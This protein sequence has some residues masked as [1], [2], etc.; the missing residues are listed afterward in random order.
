M[1]PADLRATMPVTSEVAYLN[2]GAS[3]P[4]PR[5]VVEAM[6]DW[7][8][9]HNFEAPA[10]AGIY[11]HA[12]DT[13]EAVRETIAGFLGTTPESIGLTGSTAEGISVIASSIDF[14]PGDVLVRTDLEHPAGILPFDRMADLHGLEV[15][16]LET[17]NGRLDLDDL[18]D[19]VADA[20]LLAMSSV[21]WSHG[22]RLPVEEVV[23][24]AHEAG[25]QVLIDAVQSPGQRPVDL[26]SW[27]ADFVAGSGHKWLLGP[28]GA[29]FLYVA[30]DT[31]D[32][33]TPRRIGYR[34]VEDPTGSP[35]E[36]KA[37]TARFELGTTSPAPHVG[38]ATAIDLLESVGMQSV[39]A[40]IERL[41]DRLKAGLGDRLI[42]PRDYESGLVTF[43]A[44][45][46]EATVEALAEAGVVVRPL[47]FPPGAV[48]ASVHAFNTVDDIDRLLEAL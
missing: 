27:G 11:P 10:E 41:T 1:D 26:E 30:P 20:R 38:L 47:P 32:S 39:Q 42:S 21:S 8:E 9:Y 46:P 13:Y 23:E 45:A 31:I 3:S 35:Y 24:I 33:L 18:R 17:T 19:V 37:G 36:Y 22:T 48:R 29:G 5:P 40:R 44:E 2:T 28:W 7:V 12:W 16:T 25:A 34:G 4:A 14:E 6:T 43:Q 15:R